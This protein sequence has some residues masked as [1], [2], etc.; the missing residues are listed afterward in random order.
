M[1]LSRRTFL[2]GV[3]AG[4]AAAVVGLPLLEAMLDHHG[5]SLADGLPIPKRF[6][7]WFW[8]NGSDPERWAP[9]AEGSA[10]EPTEMLA[11]LG[12]VK[13]YVNLVSGTI[14]PVPGRNNPHVEGAV[15]I[16]AGGNPVLHPSYAGQANDW[17]YLTVPG[18]SLDQ[19]AAE[20]LAGPSLFRSLTLGITPVHTAAA[21][22]SSAPG[23]A[24]SYISHRGPYL[25]N[26]PKM[27]PRQVF[28]DLFGGGTHVGP[29]PP[30]PI[31]VARADVLDAVLEDA[32]SLRVRLGSSDR[33]RLDQHLEGI[34]ELQ[35]RLNALVPSP[36]SPACAVPVDPGGPDSF[37]ARAKAM[38]DLVAMA[39]ACDLT[40]VTSI[41]FSSPASHVDYPDIY[42]GALVFNGSPTSFHE[43]EH[44]VGINDTVRVG[45]KYF[46]ECFT[47]FLLTLKAMPDAQGNLLDN[48]CVLGTSEL[49]F[50]PAHGFSDFPLLVAGKAGGALRYPGVHAAL[51]GDIAARVPFTCLKALGLPVDA[52]GEEQYRVDSPVAAILA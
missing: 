38:A 18:P 22:T 3:T 52:W 6:G 5:T 39:F 17:D 10:W 51:P 42:P 19:V 23:T 11:A 12:P 31:E 37:R 45:L 50:G 44:N 41:E 29:T 21:G 35:N 13:D 1:S 7:L 8:G 9:T 47:D 15:G 20:H 48:T 36:V 40:R 34:H 27:D 30:G 26:P 43:Y 46:I 28:T 2:R 4:S 16:L 49:S 25:F 14:L 32:A 33:Q 24:V